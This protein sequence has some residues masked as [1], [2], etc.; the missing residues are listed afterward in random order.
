MQLNGKHT[1]NASAT[2]IWKMLMDADTLAEITP[3]ITRLEPTGEDQY[4]A[5]ADVKMGPVKGSFSGDLEVAEKDEP[6]RFLLKVKQNSK[7]GNVAADV[8]IE[9]NELSENETELSFNGDARLS[10]LLAR[11]GNRVMTGVANT[12]TKQFFQA[13][14]EKINQ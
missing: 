4:K 5:I 8:S 11:T 12:L 7:I 3:G 14:E 1:F 2:T 13:M 9:L 10:G 6:N